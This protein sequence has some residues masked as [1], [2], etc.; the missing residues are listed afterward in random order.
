MGKNCLKKKIVNSRL[1]ALKD[2]LETKGK[3]R[4]KSIELSQCHLKQSPKFFFIVNLLC[5]HENGDDDSYK[6]YGSAESSPA[7]KIFFNE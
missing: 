3:Q 1:Y 4:I 5:I 6:S 2:I 7:N